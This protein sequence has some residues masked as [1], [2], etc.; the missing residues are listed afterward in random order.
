MDEIRIEG[1]RS[2]IFNRGWLLPVTLVLLFALGLG[3]RLYDLTD[4][5]L[6]FHPT[7]QLGSAVIAR[8]MYYQDLDTV[9]ED[10]RTLAVSMWRKRE[11]YEPQILERVVALTY[12]LIGGER[13]WVARVYTTTFWLIGAVGLYFLARDMSTPD[14]AI[15]AIAYVLFLPFGVMASRSFQPDPVMVA[16][17]VLSFLGLYRWRQQRGW[18]WAI[19]AGILGGVAI[20]IKLVAVFPVVGALAGI[21]LG[22]HSL[23]RVIKNR[24]VWLIGLLTLLPAAIYNLALVPERTGGL[25][26][27]WTLSFIHLLKDPS[28][29]TGWGF[30]IKEFIGFH[31]FILALWGILLF[32][33]GSERGMVMGMWVGY[34]L[35]GLT[36]PYQILTHDY[37]HLMLV[38]ILGLSLAPP[39]AV[40]FKHLSKQ[41]AIWRVAAL[42]VM[43]LAIASEVWSIR[44]DLNER[45]YRYE[46]QS[47]GELRKVFPRDGS[48]IALTQAYGYR[49]EYFAL[50][51]VPIWPSTGDMQLE[52]VRGDN[53]FDYEAEFANRTAG[54]DYF[55]V[56]DFGEYEKQDGLREIL[57]NNYPIYAQ[58]DEFIIYDL[59]QKL[60]EVGK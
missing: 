54:M 52:E 18:R 51:D 37:Y 24:Q 53:V 27:F 49:L 43:M 6:D 57:S 15:V 40:V 50:I 47:W 32:R 35:Y 11:V 2:G 5:P 59:N 29:Y 9:S 28:F 17:I 30:M 8:G 31:V 20:L 4:P 3:I 45:N 21:I 33:G 56:T 42:G 55:L 14:G 34:V 25:F 10:E 41:Q 60:E 22:E 44:G 46:A 36:L 19:L 7:R 13:L 1:E 58:G 39:M 12:H 23:R 48:A 38:P 16:F 26:G